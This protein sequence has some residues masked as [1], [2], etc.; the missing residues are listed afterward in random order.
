MEPPT[1]ESRTTGAEDVRCA[2]GALAVPELASISTGSRPRIVTALPLLH[3]CTSVSDRR[4]SRAPRDAIVGPSS[5]GAA[6]WCDF[7]PA[8]SSA[9]RSSEDDA[10]IEAAVVFGRVSAPPDRTEPVEPELISPTPAVADGGDV[11]ATSADAL[12]TP[13]PAVAGRV[14]PV[15]S[16]CAEGRALVLPSIAAGATALVA[17]L[18]P[19][20]S[21][22]GTSVMLPGLVGVLAMAMVGSVRRGRYQFCASVQYHGLGERAALCILRIETAVSS[23]REDRGST[24]AS[25]VFPKPVRAV[26][27]LRRCLQT[28]SFGRVS[29]QPTDARQRGR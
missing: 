29:V 10:E 15:I 8:A 7:P 13:E 4:P 16:E 5:G 17:V 24:S 25:E 3:A 20:A 2:R 12:G 14:V 19:A 18:I 1:G 22:A 21:S 9:A 6:S 28:T 11:P 26:R 23:A 27:T